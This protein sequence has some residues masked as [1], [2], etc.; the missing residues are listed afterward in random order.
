MIWNRQTFIKDPDSGKRQAR[1]NVPAAWINKDVP[2]LRIID[3]EVWHA[4]KARQCALKIIRNDLGVDVGNHFRDRRRPTYL[5]S[6]LVKCGC[7]GGGY[8]MISAAM[9]GCSKARNNGTCNNRKNMR[10]DELEHRVLNGL[11]SQLMH[12]DLFKVFCDEFTSETNKLRINSSA[13]I[14]AAKVELAKVEKQIAGIVGAITDGMYHP[15]MKDK[16]TQL[17]ARKLDLQEIGKRQRGAQ[18]LLHPKMAA[19]YHEQ[20][21]ALYEMLNSDIET[22]KLEA[23]GILR[24]L[25]SRIVL[26]P[27]EQGMEVKLEGDLAGML[28]LAAGSGLA[29]GGASTNGSFKRKNRPR[30][31]AGLSELKSQL[32]MV[33]GAGFEPAAFRL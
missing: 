9:L 16:M 18:P 5:L 29:K 17:E 4:T 25:I 3:D 22:P 20:M 23:S 15:S 27:T 19:M 11:K 8:A 12:P 13:S 6:G 2:K 7:C 28:S 31:A 21:D 30:G 24:T 14:D 32:E 33:A 10:R 1:L 26:T